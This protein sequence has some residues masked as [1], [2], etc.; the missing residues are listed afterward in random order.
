[1]SRVLLI[2]NDVVGENMAGPGIRYW[3]FAH[4]LGQRFPTTLAVPPFVSM[5]AIPSTETLPASLCVCNSAQDLRELAQKSDVLITL[6]VVLLLYPFIADWG[7]PLVLDMYDPFLLEGL[8]RRA[9]TD[10]LEQ[11]TSYENYLEALRV[12]LRK[13]DFFL[14]AG[15][16]QRDYWL[17]MLAAM[18]RINPYTYRQDPTLRRLID[19]VPF[20]LPSEPPYH[21][22]TILKGVYKGIKAS[23]KVVLWGG[24]IW[25]WLDAPTL[26]RAMPLIL[27]RRD[28]VK[29]FFMG[30]K[31]S[32][33]DTAKMKAVDEAITLSKELRLYDEY[34]FFNDWVPYNERQNYLLEADI[35]VSLHLDHIEARFAFRTR[36]LDYLWA[37]L[38]VVCT[39]G[40][41][42]GERLAAEDLAHLVPP[43]GVKEVAQTILS[44]LEKPDLRPIYRERSRALVNA[45]HW[46]VLTRPL[47][48]FCRSPSL[49]PDKQ[50]RSSDDL[51]ARSG[52]LIRIWRAF[53]LGGI[54]GVLQQAKEYV[55]WKMEI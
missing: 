26:I 21:T 34:V 14:C 32:N 54:S 35:G 39:E 1:M 49:A 25:D 36:M 47:V 42:M 13:G 37:G 53:R 22:Q 4:V 12:Q 29:I 55:R 8:Q 28:D 27:K 46:E 31:R 52:F 17:G 16:K 20:G 19:V 40:D 44:L 5:E 45:Y 33:Q 9:E 30:V 51:S 38:P 50:F 11:L 18:G 48:D 23:D 41:V 43:G 3:E 6:G 24:G 10:L 2:C 15:E 7:K